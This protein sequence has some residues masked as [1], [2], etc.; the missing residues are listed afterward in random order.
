LRANGSREC[1]PDDR[2]R[3]AIQFF[4]HLRW[5]AS[6][7]AQG[8]FGGL[9][10]CEARTASEEGSSL[11]LP[12]MTIGCLKTASSECAPK[13]GP[14]RA[15]L[16]RRRQRLLR[17]FPCPGRRRRHRL[18]FRDDWVGVDARKWRRQGA[19]CRARDPQRNRQGLKIIRGKAHRE[20]VVR[21]GHA[22]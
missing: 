2:L 11:S 22:D 16:R 21:G 17:L 14:A 5:I 6:A 18:K 3:E 9:P 10:P 12:A 20:I 4:F 19:A 1:A 15:L 7:C 8:R 13:I